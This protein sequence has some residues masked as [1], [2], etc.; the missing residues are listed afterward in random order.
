MKSLIPVLLLAG[1]FASCSREKTTATPVQPQPKKLVQYKYQEYPGSDL[2]FQYDNTGRLV[3]EQSNVRKYTFV[4]GI[5]T[6][7]F[8][9]FHKPQNRLIRSAEYTMNNTG[10]VT[11]SL[12]TIYDTPNISYTSDQSFEYDIE[13]YLINWKYKDSNSPD[14]YESKYVYTQGN[15]AQKADFKNGVLQM[16]I[17]YTYTNLPDKVNVDQLSSMI[18]TQELFGH[19]NKNL[20]SNTEYYDSNNVKIGEGTYSY[21][22]DTEGYPAK[23][24]FHDANVNK[25]Y[26]ISFVYD[27]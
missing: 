12:E 20:R 10:H 7:H 5:N 1:L 14:L 3:T 26:H 21:E 9:D 27:K 18:F 13:G 6:C 16:T 15:L 24:L 25:D 4:Y 8:E 23:L 11:K 19:P 2:S 22:T 17:K